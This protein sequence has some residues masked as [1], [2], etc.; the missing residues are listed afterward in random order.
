MTGRLIPYGRRRTAD[1]WRRRRQMMIDAFW[2]WA[3]IP[4]VILACC[5]D[6]LEPDE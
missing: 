3:S 6:A 4:V 5:L 1:E 2:Q